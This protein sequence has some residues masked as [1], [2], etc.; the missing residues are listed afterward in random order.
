M[1]KQT[2]INLMPRR[3]GFYLIT[4]E[5]ESRIS[6]LPNAGI[7]VFFIRHTSAALTLNE[8]VD[9]SVRVDFESF[10]DKMVPDGDHLFTH[11]GEGSDDMSAHLKA[12]LIGA[13]VTV[14]IVDG[15]LHLGTWQGIY[16]CEFR[17][18]GISRKISVTIIGE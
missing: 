1:I 11:L 13:T 9:P 6:P 17:N 2:E 12:S 5:L 10:M 15:R 18:F 4:K 14:P 8:N 3:R 7:A 16:L